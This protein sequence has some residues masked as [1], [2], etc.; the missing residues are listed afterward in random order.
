MKKCNRF[1]LNFNWEN[2]ESHKHMLVI[3]HTFL[4]FSDLQSL[5]I[6]TET[7]YIIIDTLSAARMW[8]GLYSTHME[9]KKYLQE[10]Y[11]QEI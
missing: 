3:K 7:Q 9:R 8:T 4:Q 1:K 11:V 10:L 2:F 5:P 6:C